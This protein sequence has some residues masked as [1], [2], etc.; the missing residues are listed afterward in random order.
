MSYTYDVKCVPPIRLA[1]H[2]IDL[3]VIYGKESNI[4]QKC[5]GVMGEDKNIPFARQL[6]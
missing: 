2:I 3:Q 5:L 1:S 6:G 4:G